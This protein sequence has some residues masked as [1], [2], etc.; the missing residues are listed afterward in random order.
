VIVTCE[1]LDWLRIARRALAWPAEARIELADFLE[2]ESADEALGGLADVLRVVK[3]RAVRKAD[4]GP[5][6]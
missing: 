6:S 4:K 5:A 2:H 1:R 3:L